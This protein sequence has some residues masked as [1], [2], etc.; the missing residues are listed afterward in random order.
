M[1]KILDVAPSQV[2]VERVAKSTQVTFRV[3]DAPMDATARLS[4]LLRQHSKR[5]K[6]M[7]IVQVFYPESPSTK[8]PRGSARSAALA[9]RPWPAMAITTLLGALILA[10]PL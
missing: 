1:A 9:V 6:S 3:H 2:W 5:L 10:F 8:S 7:H 4:N